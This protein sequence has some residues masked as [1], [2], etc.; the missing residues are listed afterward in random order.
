MFATGFSM[1]AAKIAQPPGGPTERWLLGTARGL[2]TA[3]PRGRRG[4]GRRR[5]PVNNALLVTPDGD[6]RALL[7]DPSLLAR[8]RGQGLRAPARASRPGR[9]PARAS[10]RRSATTCA[11]PSRSASRRTATD[12]Y[13]VIA[14]WPERRRA[15]WQTPP[16][17]A[18]DREP[19]L[20]PRRQPRRRRRQ[21]H[22][23]T[24]ATRPRSRR[25]ARRSPRP[26][27]SRPSSSST[28]TRRGGG[29][30]R[31]APRP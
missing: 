12:V 1:N 18:R 26:P 8:G 30:A 21:R 20:R 24:R 2:S 9:S 13:V 31:E 15:H 28:S 27:R 17:G 16:A 6:V 23:T 11:S 19:R 22:S 5:L 14:N 29:R 4:D 25:G 10:R 3:P 7:E